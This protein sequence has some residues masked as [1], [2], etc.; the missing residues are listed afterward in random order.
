MSIRMDTASS[1]TPSFLIECQMRSCG[2]EPMAFRRSNHTRCSGRWRRLASSIMDRT[3]KECSRHPSPGTNPFCADEMAPVSPAQQANRLPQMAAYTVAAYTAFCNEIGRRQLL[4]NASSPSLEM[5]M[6]VP[7]PVAWQ[8]F[9]SFFGDENGGALFPGTGDFLLSTTHLEDPCQDHTLGVDGFPYFVWKPIGTRCGTGALFPGTG[10]FLLST[11]HL[12]DPCQD[13]TLGVDGFPYFVWK[14]IGTR[15]GTDGSRFSWAYLPW[16]DGH[17]LPLGVAEGVEV[18]GRY[19]TSAI[20]PPLQYLPHAPLSVAAER[21]LHSLHLRSVVPL[22]SRVT[23]AVACTL[24][25]PV[26]RF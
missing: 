2:T 26:C 6:V 13:H 8:R 16:R 21:P 3:R 19:V 12:E 20:V 7:P 18:G 1:G 23:T 17:R 22:P 15:C 10:D 11:T 5:R 24:L 25:P 9:V 14:P 4:G